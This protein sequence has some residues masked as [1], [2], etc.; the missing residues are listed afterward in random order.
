MAD[1]NTPQTP[2]VGVVGQQGQTAQAPQQI[3]QGVPGVQGP[4]VPSPEQIA[5][6]MAAQAA[7]TQKQI[8]EAQRRA[9]YD[10]SQLAQSAPQSNN[11]FS[12]SA[13]QNAAPAAAPAPQAQAPAPQSYAQENIPRNIAAQM[14]PSMRPQQPPQQQP[15][16]QP[17]PSPVQGM[18]AEQVFAGPQ[19]H[20]QV[21]QQPQQQNTQFSQF[22]QPQEKTKGTVYWHPARSLNGSVNI[23]LTD[24]VVNNVPSEGAQAESDPSAKVVLALFS[25]ILALREQ[26]QWLG[27]NSQQPQANTELEQRVRGLEAALFEQRNALSQRARG[28]REQI[29]LAQAQGLTPDQILATLT[30]QQAAAQQMAQG[31]N[32]PP[33]QHIT[34]EQ[35]A[36]AQANMIAQGT[37]Q[38]PESQQVKTESE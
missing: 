25:E 36:G 27:Q 16:P 13:P 24:Y 37:G 6:V 35:Q 15:A 10:A 33:A 3:Q 11:R 4:P 2:Q 38:S 5:K 30:G 26:V 14:P 19:R 31:G 23:E 9:G 29:E 28:V 8:Q 12:N 18:T 21:T 34:A 20:S 7:A 1:Q 32:L 17:A 22:S